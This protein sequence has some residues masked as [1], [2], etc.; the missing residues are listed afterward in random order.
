MGIEFANDFEI[1][2]FFKQTKICH[3]KLLR[4]DDK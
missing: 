1:E 3:E 4:S 2:I